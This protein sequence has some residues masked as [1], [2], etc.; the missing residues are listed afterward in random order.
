M[1]ALLA[2][3][4]WRGAR[5]PRCRRLSECSKSI[6]T[7]SA[8]L[9][10]TSIL[11]RATALFGVRARQDLV[12][13]AIA[14]LIRPQRGRIAVDGRSCSTLWRRPRPRL[15]RPLFASAARCVAVRARAVPALCSFSRALSG[16]EN[17]GGDRPRA[18]RAAA[19][20][21]HGRAAGCLDA[22][23]RTR[24]SY[25]NACATLTPARPPPLPHC[26]RRA[27]V[28]VPP[29]CLPPLLFPRAAASPSR[30][31]P[32][33]RSPSSLSP[34]PPPSSAP[35]AFVRRAQAVRSGIS[36]SPSEPSAVSP[37]I[38]AV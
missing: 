20:L 36:F 7:G 6:R 17:N 9:R 25:S 21:A 12:V 26:V 16:G 15:G 34:L 35:P 30:L 31:P 37:E 38:T 14:G 5:P 2:S 3:E 23:R 19:H 33:L 29:L 1:L 24:S 28:P 11:Q 8:A 18:A 22:A 4:I 32:S 10:S 13:N 27:S